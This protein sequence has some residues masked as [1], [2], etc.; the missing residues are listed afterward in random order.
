MCIFQCYEWALRKAQQLDWS[1]HSAKAFVVIGDC[2]PHPPSYT[3]QRINWRDELDVLKGMGV[4]VTWA[5][6]IILEVGAETYTF[7]TYCMSLV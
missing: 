1:E 2:E 7:C 3:D 5:G 6:I 4:K